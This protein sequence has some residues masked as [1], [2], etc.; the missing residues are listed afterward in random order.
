MYASETSIILAGFVQISNTKYWAST[1]TVTIIRLKK[2]PQIGFIK[3][4]TEQKKHL[5]S[6]QLLPRT[7]LQKKDLL[8]GFPTHSRALW[9]FSKVELVEKVYYCRSTSQCEITVGCLL[10]KDNVAVIDTSAFAIL[11]DGWSFCC[12]MFVCLCVRLREYKHMY[13]DPPAGQ[14]IVLFMYASRDDY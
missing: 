13:T 14:C 4:A 8:L 5:H 6:F 7:T 2:L 12:I 3:L 11:P 1:R 10:W 9:D